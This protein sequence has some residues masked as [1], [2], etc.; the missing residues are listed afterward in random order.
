MNIC[1]RVWGFFGILFVSSSAVRKNTSITLVYL[2][3]SV[4]LFSQMYSH[5][6]FT[7][8]PEKGRKVEHP[9]ERAATT[10]LYNWQLHLLPLLGLPL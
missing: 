5:F 10:T 3:R 1:L 7:F 8:D 6:M 2:E 9:T 4:P